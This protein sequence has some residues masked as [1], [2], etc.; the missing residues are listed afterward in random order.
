MIIAVTGSRDW[1]SIEIVENTL[2]PYLETNT[3]VV[4]GNADGLDTIV[5]NYIE[6]IGEPSITH[7][8]YPPNWAK[9]GKSAGPIRNGAMLDH[10]EYG[11]YVQLLLAYPHSKSKGTVDCIGQAIKRLI[12]LE[13]HYEG[14]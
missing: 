9:Y 11:E 6:R 7:V 5:K 4:H 1:E 13:V 12:P 2:G 10:T 14:R 8:P 3:T